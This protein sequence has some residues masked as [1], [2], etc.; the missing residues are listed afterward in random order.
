M[1]RA[2][3]LAA[4]FVTVISL[5]AKSVSA[6]SAV[7]PDRIWFAPGPGTLDF[8][9]LFNHPEEWPR[10]R[11]LTKV[12]KVYQQHT[13][14]PPDPLV[15]PNS[16]GALASAGVFRRLNQWG[17]KTAI[18]VGSVKEFYCTADASGTNAA[19]ANTAASI[20]AVRAA[21]GAVHYLAM[22]EPFVSGR[23]K[24]CG[25][26]ALE[27]TADR[28]ATYVNGV[29]AAFPLVK[30]G[31][32]EAYPFSSEAALET[33]LHLLHAR[34][35]SPAFLH[36]DVDWSALGPDGP[37]LFARD[38]KSLQAACAAE[39]VP[40]GMILW[41]VNGDADALYMRDAQRFV[42]ALASTFSWETMPDQMIFQSWAASST[43]LRITP[44][45]L[46]E[47]AQDT[48][49]QFLWN[50]YR[51]LRGQISEAHKYKFG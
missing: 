50:S 45:N 12:F 6:P 5:S 47:A 26:P 49:T 18:E 17:I 21:G 16:Y 27:P 1:T 9:R 39:K 23:A 33:I 19:I 46:P 29:H 13:L 8:L 20:E 10:A 35:A 2:I 44:T 40:F 24:V 51:R 22:D 31:L 28:I 48:H 32:I 30:V 3:A 42:D 43:G 25:G 38:M 7:Q 11:T 36:M 41:G 37:T 15:G 14:M 34:G 4:V